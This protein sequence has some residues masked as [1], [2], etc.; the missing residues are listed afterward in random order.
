MNQEVVR[1]T[2]V[3]ASMT[4]LLG[5]SACGQTSTV[6]AGG[7]GEDPGIPQ[8]TVGEAAND[9]D[10]EVVQTTLPELGAS[11]L[12]LLTPNDLPGWQLSAPQ[13]VGDTAEDDIEGC[14]PFV[15]LLSASRPTDLIVRGSSNLAVAYVSQVVIDDFPD[16][17]LIFEEAD[18]G[19]SSCSEILA[20]GQPAVLSRGPA[21]DAD[22]WQSTAFRYDYADGEYWVTQASLFQNTLVITTVGTNDETQDDQWLL[23]LAAD[24]LSAVLFGDAAFFEDTEDPEAMNGT[25]M[26][27]HVG[28]DSNETTAV[29]SDTTLAET[30]STTQA[31]STTSGDEQ[32]EDSGLARFILTADEIGPRWGEPVTIRTLPPEPEFESDGGTCPGPPAFPAQVRANYSGAGNE[33]VALSAFEAPDGS[34]QPFVEAFRQLAVCTFLPDAEFVVDGNGGGMLEAADDLYAI[35]LEIHDKPAVFVWASFGDL[36]LVA[37]WQ[38][39][40]ANATEDAPL[41]ELLRS[42]E[43]MAQ[44]R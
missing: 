23:P 4:L 12:L 25:T 37:Y 24:R 40:E 14:D 28:T 36:V 10:S 41:D 44:R 43:V 11:E 29:G 27:T 13:P 30:T 18:V 15:A 1:N 9:P 26:T 6:I 34:G 22:G 35:A 20:F 3:A 42:I 33:Y 31:P 5:A 38:A 39:D 21:T 2:L 17:N 32:A 16:A 7:T 8:T 19:S